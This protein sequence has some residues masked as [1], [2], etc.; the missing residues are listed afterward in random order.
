MACGMAYSSK[1]LDKISNVYFTIMGDA[2]TA[3]GSVWEAVNFASFYKL[4]NLI[5]IVD[6]N[7]LGQG[8]E[9]SL[10]VN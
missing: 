1:Y 4:N 5:A 3:E 2:E 8:T 10:K 7:R 6:V 9:T